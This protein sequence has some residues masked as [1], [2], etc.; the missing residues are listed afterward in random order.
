MISAHVA[1]LSI[2]FVL[3]LAGPALAQSGE[4]VAVL[5]EARKGG[6][7]G[8]IR[9]KLAGKDEWRAPQPLM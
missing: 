1:W 7:D 3:M 6:P 2:A 9:V 4:A 5:T 8:E